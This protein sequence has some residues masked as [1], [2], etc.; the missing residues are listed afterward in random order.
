MKWSLVE[1]CQVKKQSILKH[2]ELFLVC[3]CYFVDLEQIH[4]QMKHF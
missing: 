3:E 2:F 4:M 1:I